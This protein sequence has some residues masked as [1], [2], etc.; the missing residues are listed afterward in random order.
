[1]QRPFAERTGREGVRVR[2]A[3]VFETD[4]W[5]ECDFLVMELTKVRGEWDR[6]G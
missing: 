1:V 5:A 4:A 3:F 6:G 2:V